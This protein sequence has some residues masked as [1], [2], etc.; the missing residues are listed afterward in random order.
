MNCS[1]FM[2]NLCNWIICLLIVLYSA[3]VFMMYCVYG[4]MYGPGP[5][6]NPGEAARCGEPLVE[7]PGLV[8]TSLDRSI[9]CW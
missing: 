9:T 2:F 7:G 5:E 8:S 4:F 3:I 1:Y 6:K